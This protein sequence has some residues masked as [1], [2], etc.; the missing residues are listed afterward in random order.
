M[1]FLLIFIDIFSRYITYHSLLTNI[2]GY[3]VSRHFKAAIS[4]LNTQRKPRLQTDN[5]SCYVSQEFRE[6]VN[7][8]KVKHNFITPHCPN[9]NAEVERCNRTL[10]EEL[11]N[12]PVA[13]TF[14]ELER[15]IEKMIKYYNEERYHSSLNYMPPKIYYRGNPELLKKERVKKLE[16]ARRERIRANLIAYKKQIVSSFNSSF[17]PNFR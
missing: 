12:Y 8:L 9:Q 16:K 5:G 6:V 4:K 17:C 7:A 15:I 3:T 10:K 11:L 13:K 1:Y 14:E 2:T